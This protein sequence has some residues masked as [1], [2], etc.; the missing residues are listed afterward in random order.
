MRTLFSQQ[1]AAV[2]SDAANGKTALASEKSTFSLFQY[3]AGTAAG[4]SPAVGGDHWQRGS[5]QRNSER[6]QFL[7]TDVVNM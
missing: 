2:Q 1:N 5:P 4:N 3:P 7:G 6:E